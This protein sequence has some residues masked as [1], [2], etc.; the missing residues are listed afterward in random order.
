MLPE[1]VQNVKFILS[2]KCKIREKK[3]FLQLKL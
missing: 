1:K 3:N 2:V